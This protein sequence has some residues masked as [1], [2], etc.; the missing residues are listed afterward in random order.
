MVCAGEQDESICKSLLSQ[1]KILRLKIEDCEAQTLARI[2]QPSDREQLLKD[3]L[4]KTEQQKSL[5]SELEGISKSLASLSEKAQPLEASAEQSS[6]EVLRTELKITLQK[7]QHT[8]SISTIYLEKLKTVEVVIRSTQGAEDVVK[9]YEN[10]L[11]EVHTVPTSL[12]EVEH[13]CSELQIMR[14]EADS[15]G[16]LFDLVE[17][18]LSKAS[19]V[20][21]RML[22]VH[23]E[24]D[25]ELEQHRQV[26]GSLQDRWRAVLAQMELRQRELQMLGR[27]LEYYRQSYDWLIRWIAD[28][29][30]R[31]E[32]IQAVPITDSKTLKEQLAQ[33]K[34]RNHHNFLITL[35][36]FHSSCNHRAKLLEEIEKNKEKVDE[37]QKYA[38]NYIDTI[39]DYELQLVAYKAQ[40]EPLTSPLKK[41]KMESASDNII[42]EYVTLRTRY[43]ELMT[44]TSQ[45]IK[46]ITDTQRRL[47]DEEVR[48]TKGTIMPN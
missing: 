23:S 31:Q 14:S 29:K 9:K 4:Q 10:R 43:S 8:Q 42:Q 45:Y 33:E 11:R 22:Q 1:L 20:S 16:P 46:F 13:Y 2:R 27:Q 35:K 15:Q 18:D 41:T 40:V 28:A 37:C 7:M 12:P 38:K 48:E 30:Q 34:V 24:R 44:L 26:L 32:D 25:V 3:C 47:D 5:Q 36:I 17:S 6:G 39:K 19:V 21:Q